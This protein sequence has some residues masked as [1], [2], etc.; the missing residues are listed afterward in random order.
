MPI[1]S[2]PDLPRMLSEALEHAETAL[3]I[4]DDGQRLLYCNRAFGRL[5]G[6]APESLVGRRSTSWWTHGRRPTTAWK[7]W[8]AAMT[9][10]ASGAASPAPG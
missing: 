6:H 1:R 7:P 8:C 5:L 10:G 3:C 4:N 9:A 2:I